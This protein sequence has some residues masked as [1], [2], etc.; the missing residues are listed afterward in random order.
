MN[1]TKVSKVIFELTPIPK[2]L[3]KPKYRQL[4]LQI[5]NTSSNTLIRNLLSINNAWTRDISVFLINR[6]K[7]NNKINKESKF[8]FNFRNHYLL[9][10]NSYKHFDSIYAIEDISQ[11]KLR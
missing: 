4:A 5:L 11:L 8:T 10:A 3:R 6:K 7:N 1:E 2:E 9:Y